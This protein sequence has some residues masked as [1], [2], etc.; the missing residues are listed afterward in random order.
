MTRMTR[1]W[2]YLFL[3]GCVALALTFGWLHYYAR[4]QVCRAYYPELSEWICIMSD[5]GLPPRGRH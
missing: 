3:V 5:H 2:S 4:S 1:I